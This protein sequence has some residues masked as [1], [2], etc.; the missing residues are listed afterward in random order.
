MVH[1]E[2]RAI[3]KNETDTSVQIWEFIQEMLTFKKMHNNAKN[4]FPSVSKTKERKS[5]IQVFTE[6]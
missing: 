5:Y 3:L 1:L 2:S 6:L 4:I